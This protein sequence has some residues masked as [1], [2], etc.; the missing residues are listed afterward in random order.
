[1]LP[2]FRLLAL[3]P[4]LA[5]GLYARAM[6]LVSDWISF[7]PRLGPFRHVV[8]AA[9]AYLVF[10]VLL[11]YVVAPVRGLV[12]HYYQGDKLRYDAERWLATAIYDRNGA[13]A[14]TFDARLDSRRDVNY[15]DAPIEVGDYTA[16]PD[17]KSIPVRV[18][19]ERYWQCL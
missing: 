4:E 3:V 18:T 15:T 12:G 9:V 10:A 19:P 6:R 16:N 8:T 17:H 11:V 7:S 2:L 1:M 14:G 5:L 13:F